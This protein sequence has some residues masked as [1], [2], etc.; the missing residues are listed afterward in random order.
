MTLVVKSIVAF[1]A[2]MFV[3]AAIQNAGLLSLRQ[4]LGSERAMTAGVPVMGAIPNHAMSDFKDGI[5][6][7]LPAIDTTTGQR[8]AIEGLA[9]RTDLQ[10]RAA[11]SA[12]PMPMRIPGMPR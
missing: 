9:R 8:L 2:G 10:I 3:V 11:Q 4:Y 1:C 5:L 6:P 7:K 12:V